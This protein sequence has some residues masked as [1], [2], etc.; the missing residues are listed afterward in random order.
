MVISRTDDVIKS[1]DISAY[2]KMIINYKD[3]KDYDI[4]SKDFESTNYICVDQFSELVVSSN[5]RI[6]V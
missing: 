3:N 4:N 1:F 5:I 2:S 6:T